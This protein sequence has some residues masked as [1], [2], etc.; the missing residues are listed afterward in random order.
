MHFTIKPDTLWYTETT[1]VNLNS[2]KVNKTCQYIVPLYD[3]TGAYSNFTLSFILIFIHLTFMTFVLRL[4]TPECGKMICDTI[5]VFTVYTVWYQIPQ[6]LFK[7]FDI[8]ITLW[9][10]GFD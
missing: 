6:R 4:H 10:L 3:Q 1:L 9:K 8:K 2:P 5:E 7:H